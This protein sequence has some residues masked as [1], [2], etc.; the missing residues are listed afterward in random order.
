VS[1]H[2]PGPAAIALSAALLAAGAGAAAPCPAGL[3]EVRTAQLVFGR[4][5]G[6]RPGVSDADWRDFVAH[7]VTPRFPDGITVID[8][9]G[10]WRGRAGRLVQEPS[11]M[12]L[13][14]L[15]G[16]AGEADRLAAI[17]RTYE[18]RFRQE[19]V[20]LL[21]QGGCATFQP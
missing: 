18:A 2:R 19:S 16:D 8:A 17:A 6:D 13:I 12:L 5:I 7:E 11:K 15:K 10:Q 9:Q 21:E 4:D 20:L 1:R 14:V 3:S